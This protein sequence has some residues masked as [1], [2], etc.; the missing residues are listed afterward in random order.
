LLFKG[1]GLRLHRLESLYHQ[2]LKTQNQ[3]PL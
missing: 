1:V 3:K 2:K